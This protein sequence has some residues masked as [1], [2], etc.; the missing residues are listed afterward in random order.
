ML[1]SY[2]FLLFYQVIGIGI[3][4]PVSINPSAVF[5][6]CRK[7]NLLVRCALVD[8]TTAH[9]CVY[10]KVKILGKVLFSH[11]SFS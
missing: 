9:F 1:Q 3:D 8:T 7:H 11:K 5:R 6:A 10:C 2:K 4:F